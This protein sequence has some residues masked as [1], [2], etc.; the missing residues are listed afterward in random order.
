MGQK[1]ADEL[2]A[3]GVDFQRPSLAA[4]LDGSERWVR[5]P[6]RRL[7]W[8]VSDRAEAIAD[9]VRG[10]VALNLTYDLNVVPGLR[11]LRRSLTEAFDAAPA[12]WIASKL[13]REPGT[14]IGLSDDQ[15]HAADLW[16]NHFST[17][18]RLAWTS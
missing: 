2:E 8:G 16:I 4:A 13:R 12:L 11:G 17:M 7:E 1:F 9:P 5:K 3:A 10:K 18:E 6:V 14:V 15:P